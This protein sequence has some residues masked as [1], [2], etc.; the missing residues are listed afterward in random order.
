MYVKPGETYSI[1]Y[2]YELPY[3]VKENSLKAYEFEYFKQSGM[4]NESLET[5]LIIDPSMSIENTVST[6]DIVTLK[7]NSFQ[8]IGKV[9]KNV[10]N[11]V[12]ID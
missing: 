4:K 7:G 10:K 9:K 2:T 11:T 3:K 1:S 5:N 6:N 8:T 12:F